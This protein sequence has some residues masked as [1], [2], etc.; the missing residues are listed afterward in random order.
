MDRAI[1]K[2]RPSIDE[3]REFLTKHPYLGASDKTGRLLMQ[4]VAKV[5]PVT[6]GG[7]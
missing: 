6:I 7:N 5:E 2:H 4:T 1:A 3:F